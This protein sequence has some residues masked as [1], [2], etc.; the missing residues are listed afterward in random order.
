MTHD[1]LNQI[2]ALKAEIDQLKKDLDEVDRRADAA[3]RKNAE[4]LESRQSEKEWLS[5]AK[6]EA[7][8]DDNVSF[9][10]VWAETLAKARQFDSPDGLGEENVPRPS[11]QEATLVGKVEES[12]FRNYYQ[13]SDCDYVWDDVWSARCEDDCPNCGHRH[14][15]PYH[16]ED[17]EDANSTDNP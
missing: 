16:S 15:S 10:V 5:K 4:L 12:L 8:Y 14:I 2:E 9:D 13:C 3:E 6:A 7:G 11:A 1:Y 17:F